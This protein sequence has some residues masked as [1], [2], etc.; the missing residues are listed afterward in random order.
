MRTAD[1]YPLATEKRGPLAVT[2]E[3]RAGGERFRFDGGLAGTDFSIG[4]P[5]RHTHW[6]WAMIFGRDRGGR[7]VCVNL[8]EGHIG[9][10]ECAERHR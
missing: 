4:L 10:P 6:R 9:A 3:V 2:G 5:P 8:V 1:G 7:A